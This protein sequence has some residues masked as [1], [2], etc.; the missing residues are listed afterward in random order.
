MQFLVLMMCLL[1]YLNALYFVFFLC[2]Y[3]HEALKRVQIY[4]YQKLYIVFA[5]CYIH[6]LSKLPLSAVFYL[7][8]LLS[9][10]RHVLINMSYKMSHHLHLQ[11][12]W[13]NRLCQCCLS[14]LSLMFLHVSNYAKVCQ[15]C[16]ET[17]YSDAQYTWKYSGSNKISNV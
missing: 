8:E 15:D 14:R 10:F 16:N 1:L 2:S 13:N 4:P 17:L 3:L 7:W 12:S 9:F 6:S 11:N 5:M